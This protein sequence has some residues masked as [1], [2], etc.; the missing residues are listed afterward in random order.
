MKLVHSRRHTQNDIRKILK[1]CPRVLYF[2]LHSLCYQ[3]LF[4]NVYEHELI[5]C[6]AC[7]TI[8]FTGT[9]IFKEFVS[10]LN[11]KF[12]SHRK[13]KPPWTMAQYLMAQNLIH[14]YLFMSVIR[15]SFRK[16]HEHKKLMTT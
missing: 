4:T 14:T 13:S 3:F 7:R 8:I 10:R 5:H 11:H 6:Q 15:S 1:F 12:R 2:L 9:L 16:N